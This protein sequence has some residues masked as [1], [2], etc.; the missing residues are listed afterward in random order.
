MTTPTQLPTGQL[1]AF[2]DDE[3]KDGL[4]DAQSTAGG[5]V[6]L[7]LEDETGLI[8]VVCSLGVWTRYRRAARGSSALLIRGVV[9]SASNVINL[10]AEKIETLSLSITTVPG[11]R[12]FR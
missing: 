10:R 12:D 3:L 9:E 5:T 1:L 6:F 2:V 4:A 7:N 8:N 11:S